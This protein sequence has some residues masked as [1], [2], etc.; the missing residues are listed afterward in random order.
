MSYEVTIGIP[1]YNAEKY[2]RETMDAALAQTFP[3]IEFLILD[4][5]GTDSSMD[6][7]ND[8]RLHHERGKDIR[9][10]RQPN[11]KGIGAARNRLLDEAIGTW[12][13]FLDAD[14]LLPANAIELLATAGKAKNAEV[15]MGSHERLDLYGG[16]HDHSIVRYVPDA[17]VMRGDELAV[18][19]FSRYGAVGANVWNMLIRLDFVRNYRLRF[20]NTNY[21]EDMV[22]KMEMVTYT[23]CAV[24]LP[25]IT[26]T[27]ICR[28]NTLSNFQR[29][30]QIGKDE[31]LCNAASVATL[32]RNWQRLL[33]KKYFHDWFNTILM[34]EFYVA[35]NAIRDK[36]RIIPPLSDEELRT[37]VRMPLTFPQTLRYAGLRNLLFSLL[38]W[39]PPA[40]CRTCITRMGKHRKLI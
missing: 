10:I 37:I 2:I 1:V 18:Y 30:K 5:C 4:D 36:E 16:R 39:M 7:I 29:R 14:D 34:T 22:F 3:S 38:G 24:L 13:Y 35:C 8:Y 21:W 27:Y 31:I 25:D 6:I 11:N 19:T 32:M 40:L 9:I 28:E 20:L 12:L 26:Y 17:C 33:A 23:K 15:I